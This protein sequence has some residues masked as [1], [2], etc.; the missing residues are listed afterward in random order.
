MFDNTQ[1]VTRFYE[2][3]LNKGDL[4]QLDVLFSDGSLEGHTCEELLAPEASRSNLYTF[5]SV[6]EGV[7][8]A[9]SDIDV[10]I[11]QIS[12]GGDMVTVSWTMSGVFNPTGNEFEYA[13]M[14]K[15]RLKEGKI[16][17]RWGSQNL[18]SLAR[19]NLGLGAKMRLP[20]EATDYRPT[21]ADQQSVAHY[22]RNAFRGETA[23]EVFDA[24]F[25]DHSPDP[26][27]APGLGGF[28]RSLRG[29]ES[30][31]SLPAFNIDHMK[32]D[33]DKVRVAWTFVGVLDMNKKKVSF[34]GT[35]VWAVKDGKIQERWGEYDLDSLTRAF[36]VQ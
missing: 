32:V 6:L 7:H 30:A 18:L 10:T 33:G 8:K 5:R 27:Q 34:T 11:D 22:Y 1:I 15:W 12:A 21:A 9:Y 31:F 4:S 14:D 28:V 23:L 29:F 35:E 17:G 19:Q 3:V 2:E 13:G 24:D 16:V 26:G 36:G 25:V 20:E